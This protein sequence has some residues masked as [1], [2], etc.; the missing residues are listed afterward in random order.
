M[1]ITNSKPDMLITLRKIYLEKA[2]LDTDDWPWVLDTLKNQC[3]VLEVAH[4]EL[5]N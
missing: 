4:L 1:Y 3:P 5:M 2:M